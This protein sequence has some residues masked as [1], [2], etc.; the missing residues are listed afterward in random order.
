MTDTDRTKI[1]HSHFGFVYITIFAIFASGAAEIV[2]AY[3]KFFYFLFLAV[4]KAV[5]IRNKAKT[6]KPKVLHH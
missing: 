4:V 6:E 1:P 5:G 3:E 2:T